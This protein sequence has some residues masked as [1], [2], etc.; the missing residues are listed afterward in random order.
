MARNRDGHRSVTAKRK[1]KVADGPLKIDLGCGPN[2]REG[3]TGV[4]RIKFHAVDHVADLR[5]VWP[6]ADE[7]VDEAHSSHFVEHLTAVE[8]VHFCNE[9]YRVLKPGGKCTM[10]VP[11][12]ASCRAYGDPTHQWPPVSEFWFYYLMKKWR[13]ENAP[14]TDIAHWD[15]GFSCNFEVTWGYNVSPAIASRSQDFQQFAINHYREAALDTHA[16][17]TRL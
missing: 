17:L 7:S 9:L 13:D 8:R 1:L 10:I 15:Q 2:K 14:H 11:H 4:D 5:E 16:T 12:W 6:F 3:F